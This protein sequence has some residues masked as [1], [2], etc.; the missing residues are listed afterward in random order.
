MGR[1]T[2]KLAE[3][4]KEGDHGAVT[5]VLISKIGRENFI[6]RAENVFQTFPLKNDSLHGVL[7]SLLFKGVIT[8]AWDSY[9]DEVFASPA[10]KRLT[11]QTIHEIPAILRTDEFF[12]FHLNGRLETPSDVV[13]TSREL[14]QQIKTISAGERA[15]MSLFNGNT[16][17]FV[18]MSPAG[19]EQTL[20][21]LDISAGDRRHYA[22]VPDYGFFEVDKPRFDAA[23]GIQL[24]P[25]QPDQNFQALP[26]F[27][28]K[29]KAEFDE[30]VV[31]H[32]L[33]ARS[34][35]MQ[36]NPL[37]LEQL[38]L[39]N[40]GPY[41]KLTIKFTAGW[42]V[43]V[44]NN[45]CGK[46][47]L[48][49]AIGFAL[50]GDEA[51]LA[52]YAPYMLRTNTNY[53]EICLTIDGKKYLT[54][55]N[56]VS[57]TVEAVAHQITPV[58]TRRWM[59]LGFPAVRGVPS[60]ACD[61]PNQMK[62]RPLPDTDDIMPL[63]RDRTDDRF[64]NL[65]QWIINTVMSNHGKPLKTVQNFFKVLNRIIPDERFEYDHIDKENWEVM[66][67]TSNGIVPITQVSHG[68]GSVFAWAGTLVQRMH[69]I[70]PSSD[71]TL[72]ETALVL[73]DEVDAHLHPTWQLAIAGIVRDVFPNIQLIAT[74]HSPLI[75]N[76][77][78]ANEI[79]TA[80][81]TDNGS[82]TIQASTIDPRGMRADQILTSWI[83]GLV[84]T[85]GAS[86]NDKI[87]HYSEL[88]S[89]GRTPTRDEQ[90]LAELAAEVDRI[91]QS[92]E[93]DTERKALQVTDAAQELYFNKAMGNIATLSD[94][95]KVRFTSLVEE[96]LGDVPMG[97]IK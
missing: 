21:A 90:R 5:D 62:K 93:T 29:L 7:Q 53:G 78:E 15:L 36:V 25:Y 20:D 41:E 49:K 73:I 71:N 50:C 30:R 81:I 28:K 89:A 47:T 2:P 18:G 84:S 45:G 92:G 19:I 17:L 63:V 87:K 24:I 82:A 38:Q 42:N 34:A 23:Y 27:F 33:S 52:K 37:R 70:Y 43:V 80:N 60:Q 46:S 14:R 74:T 85:R 55:L 65:Q 94:E 16:L 83:F 66:V 76:D 57:N 13:M 22:L 1:L 31:K 48:L 54:K 75:V 59:A 32:E 96:I 40:I 72:A 26:L 86:S 3:Y 68:M 4:L 79:F 61:G 64:D 77:L 56:R 95:D 10:T 11:P 91:T 9:I 88:L 35:A 44:G 97:T 67:K 12:I 58:Q 51:E 8:T 6:R 69:D 39:K